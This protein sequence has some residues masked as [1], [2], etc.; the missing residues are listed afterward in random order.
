[1]KTVRCTFTAKVRFGRPTRF[2]RHGPPATLHAWRKLLAS[3][4][5]PSTD[6]S[7]SCKPA[8]TH[9]SSGL[10]LECAQN[11]LAYARLHVREF[12]RLVPALKG[13]FGGSLPRVPT[14]Q[15]VAT[16]LAEDG[17][18]EEAISVCLDALAH[19]LQDGT[20]SGFEGRISRIRRKQ[21]EGVQGPA[22]RLARQ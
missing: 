16:V 18:F 14:F 6:I 9:T 1:M 3:L 13:D 4:R 10:T 8:S 21:R 20:S 7:S 15:N 22:G 17:A 5:T 11:S 2:M 19:G 12:P